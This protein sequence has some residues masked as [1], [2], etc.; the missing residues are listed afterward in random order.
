M[1][2]GI[3][4]KEEAFIASG[5]HCCLCHKFCGIKIEVHH[6]LL[7][8]EGGPDTIENAIALCFDCHADMS[9]YDKKHPKG[10]KY[11]PSELKKHR[12][13]WY[14][15]V[16]V[17]PA[18]HY[19]QKSVE[20]DTEVFNW[21]M[22]YLPWEVVSWAKSND[23]SG[24][25][26]SMIYVDNLIHFDT[27][28]QKPHYEFLD[29]DLEGLRSD[30]R[31]NI[32]KFIREI[33]CNTWKLNNS[34]YYS[35]PPEWEIEEPERFKTVLNDIHSYGKSIGQSYANI[36]RESRRRLGVKITQPN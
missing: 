6:I 34:Y 33:S 5:R 11:T 25:P 18:P 29:A 36:I 26:F 30:L 27:E 8:S 15:K 23:F 13:L 9:S 12:D 1:G 21:I 35:V 7:A 32:R 3:K 10:S 19:N 4:V 31:I 16:K 20:L 24:F 17:S 2:F 14:E 22:N 28:S